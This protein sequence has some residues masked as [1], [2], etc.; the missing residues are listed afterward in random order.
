M[1][2][3]QLENYQPLPNPVSHVFDVF[4]TRYGN[5]KGKFLSFFIFTVHF[6][7]RRRLK[8]AFLHR[9][10]YLGFAKPC[11]FILL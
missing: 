7:K 8:I 3:E 10:Y 11:Q 2:D 4:Y 6:T 1:P 5:E 9:K